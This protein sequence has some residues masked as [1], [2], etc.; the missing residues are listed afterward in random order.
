MKRILL[1]ICGLLLFFGNVSAQNIDDRC[2]Q[3]G[4]SACIDWDRGVV[5][6]EGLGVPAKFANNPALQNASAQRAARLDAARNI[7]EMIKGINISSVTTVKEAMVANDTIRTR[8]QG[9][10]HG[11]RPVGEPRYFSDGT[12]KLRMEARLQ[13]TIPEE[14]LYLNQSKEI[15]Q[16]PVE[17]HAGSDRIS[18]PNTDPQP[19]G[20]QN[21]A[22][23]ATSPTILP[24]Q[25]GFNV[26]Q[27][28]T[29]MI[30]DARNT[31]IQPAMS[32]KVFDEEGN[33]IYGSAYVDREFVVKHGMAG[34]L[35][36]IEKAKTN[37]RVKG[38]PLVIKAL[39]SAGK[40]KTDL[41]VNNNDAKALRQVAATQSFLR[42]A[43]VVIVLD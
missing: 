16:P 18:S 5:I 33:E 26:N 40:N 38:T 3:N 9:Y 22:S 24:A 17:I 30:I 10:L 31:G 28:Y 6:S 37:D 2:I 36:D 12:I 15:V 7:L 20:S 32:P 27:V 11:L 29:G 43:R 21:T 39:K 19:T 4:P 1:G 41:V 35:K 42:E 8:I 23:G 25:S 13:R 34:Y 14:L